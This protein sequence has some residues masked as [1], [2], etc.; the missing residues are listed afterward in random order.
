MSLFARSE[1]LEQL[2]SIREFAELTGYEKSSVYNLINDGKLRC[3]K[4]GRSNRIPRSA[5]D[6]FFANCVKPRRRATAAS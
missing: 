3:V 2:H 1:E 5:I 6:E 4:I